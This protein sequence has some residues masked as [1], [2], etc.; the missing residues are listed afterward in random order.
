MPGWCV[1]AESDFSNSVH[2]VRAYK[3]NN[4]SALPAKVYVRAD[5]RLL[6]LRADA[7]EKGLEI[8]DEQ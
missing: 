7:V 8:G 1:F 6:R 5:I 3:G 4:K 2:H